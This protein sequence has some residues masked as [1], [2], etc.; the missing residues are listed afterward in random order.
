MPRPDLRRLSARFLLDH[1]AL[2][3]DA[4]AKAPWHDHVPKD[5]FLNDVLPYACISGTREARGARRSAIPPLPLSP[6]PRRR[7]KRP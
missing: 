6:E 1:V 3:Y 7:V 2:I 4:F 5:I